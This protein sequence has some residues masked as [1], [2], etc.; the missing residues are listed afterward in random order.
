MSALNSS[1]KGT[2]TEAKDTVQYLGAV[3]EQSLSSENMVRCI[4]MSPRR[5]GGRRI[6]FGV[7]LVGVGMTVSCVHDILWTSQRILTKFAW[8]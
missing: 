1:I 3:L 6:V 7:D 5:R 2:D 8:I 4:I